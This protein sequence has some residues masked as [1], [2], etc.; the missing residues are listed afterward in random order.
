MTRRMWCEWLLSM[1]SL[2]ACAPGSASSRP[3]QEVTFPS[4]NQIVDGELR[5]VDFADGTARLPVTTSVPVACSIVY[6]TT[7]EFGS[8]AVDLDMAGGA[9]SEHNPLLT[10]LQSNT[11]YYYRVQGVDADGN[12]YISEVM[13]FTT[14]DF[15]APSSGSENLASPLRG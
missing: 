11:V 1:I 7:P 9:H 10:G 8:L 5:V 13:T 4:I 14:P 12:V 6:G 3:T 2:A 15:E